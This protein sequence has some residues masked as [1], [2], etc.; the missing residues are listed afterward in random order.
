MNSTGFQ[1]EPWLSTG[2]GGGRKVAEVVD[3]SMS[4]VGAYIIMN[5]MGGKEKNSLFKTRN[6]IKS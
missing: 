3:I 5:K 2:G 6:K 1:N 4:E